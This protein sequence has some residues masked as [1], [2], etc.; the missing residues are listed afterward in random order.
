[1]SNISC[2][3]SFLTVSVDDLSTFSIRLALLT[4]AVNFSTW[5][6]SFILHHS[7]RKHILKLVSISFFCVCECLKSKRRKRY[8]CD[9]R[10]YLVFKEKTFSVACF[11]Y[12]S[13]ARYYSTDKIK[14][15]I[16]SVAFFRKVEIEVLDYELF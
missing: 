8:F 16:W 13:I 12:F 11:N 6:F 3:E 5:V 7:T 1:M 2:W 15:G 10:N 4:L 9:A 14:L